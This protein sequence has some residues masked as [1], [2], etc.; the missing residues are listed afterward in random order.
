MKRGGTPHGGKGAGMRLFVTLVALLLPCPIHGD[1]RQ[2]AGSGSKQTESFQTTS[3]EW[4]IHRQTYG[5]G[6]FSVSVFNDDDEL[7]S[8]AANTLDND[9]GTS[10]VSMT[11]WASERMQQGEV[12]MV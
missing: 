3:K 7:V 9:G 12:L 11:L 6:V 8:L 5:E 4:R 10:Y 1:S 2:W